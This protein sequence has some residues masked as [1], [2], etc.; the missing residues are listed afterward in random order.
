LKEASLLTDEEIE[1]I[2]AA[3]K[4]ILIESQQNKLGLN[5]LPEITSS[6][7]SDN[8][9][10]FQVLW[11][12]SEL[13]KKGQIKE[14]KTFLEKFNQSNTFSN[15]QWR[16]II[17]V[18]NLIGKN[19]TREIAELYY[20]SLAFYYTGHLEK[21]REGL[22]E[23]LKIEST[24]PAIAKIIKDDLKGIESRSSDSNRKKEIAELY[25][26]SM[27]FYHAGQLEKAREG[28]VIVLNSGL[29]PAPMMITIKDY[30]TKIDKILGPQAKPSNSDK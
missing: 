22:L 17:Q 9:S 19:N 30:L 13:I 11:T 4:Q 16:K 27:S 12:V 25:Y 21:A 20:R 26:R 6:P 14:A 8:N 3:K 28:L 1:G 29:V 7:A 23:T 15:E 5:D 24:P 2:E 18:F 10:R